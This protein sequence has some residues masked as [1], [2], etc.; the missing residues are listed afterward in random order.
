MRVFDCNHGE[1]KKAV[2]HQTGLLSK[3]CVRHLNVFLQK[4]ACYRYDLLLA[5]NLVQFPSGSPSAGQARRH[6]GC[7][8]C[9]PPPL[10]ASPASPHQT[11]KGVDMTLDFIENHRQ[12]HFCTAHYL[13]AKDTKS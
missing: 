11:N 13:I 1:I 10:H 2:C 9:I 6:G 7:R 12:I 4:H 8:G 5:A 3:I